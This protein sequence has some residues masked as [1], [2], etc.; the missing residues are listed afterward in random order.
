MREKWEH[1]GEDECAALS[2]LH[3]KKMLIPCTLYFSRSFL[4]GCS[5]CR[6]GSPFLSPLSLTPSFSLLP[7]PGRLAAEPCSSQMTAVL[8]ATTVPPP[9]LS[10]SLSLPLGCIFRCVSLPQQKVWA[11]RG[12]WQIATLECKLNPVHRSV[13]FHTHYFSIP[14]VS[15]PPPSRIHCWIPIKISVMYSLSAF[16]R[17]ALRMH[18]TIYQYTNVIQYIIYLS[19]HLSCF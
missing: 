5:S 12:R 8:H 10:L 6:P 3:R 9:F 16:R 2:L 19:I 13:Y 18:G 7:S 4:S 17:N 1:G 11:D 15:P 14:I